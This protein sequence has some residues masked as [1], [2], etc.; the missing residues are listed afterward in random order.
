MN[1][2]ASLVLLSAASDSFDTLD[3]Q[4]QISSQRPDLQ[5]SIERVD[6]DNCLRLTSG[7]VGDYVRTFPRPVLASERPFAQAHIWLPPFE[8]W[9]QTN[10]NYAGFRLTITRTQGG[11]VWP[12]I[13]I[14]R[15][16]NGPC[17]VPR[18]LSDLASRSIS[19]AG[20][21]TLGIGEDRNARLEFYAKPGTSSSLTEADRFFTDPDPFTTVQ[22]FDGW[23]LQVATPQPWF[24]ADVQ[25]YADV[26]PL[27]ISRAGGAVAL[28]TGYP[29]MV[30]ERST[31]LV[32]WLPCA[33]PD[34]ITQP[35][36]FYRAR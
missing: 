2:L 33:N 4:W 19:Q 16:I 5:A 34:L 15:G 10:Q 20:W 7:S 25:L 32:A 8:Q 22:S 6:G 1:L 21:W 9:P 17:F 29:G 31:D 18:V 26:P 24:F 11:F 14:A 27:T 23:F 13:F 28:T 12:G 3:S 36:Q 35:N 30:I